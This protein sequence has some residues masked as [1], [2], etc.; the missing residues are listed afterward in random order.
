MINYDWEK[1]GTKIHHIV[2]SNKN[3][4]HMHR[5]GNRSPQRDK[6]GRGNIVKLRTC[7]SDEWMSS[8][9]NTR[10]MLVDIHMEQGFL[11]LTRWQVARV[12]LLV[13]GKI[14]VNDIPNTIIS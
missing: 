5:K 6:R 2:A 11:G 3:Q 1:T 13:Q 8:A 14:M 12:R 9:N 10:W 4:G 7:P